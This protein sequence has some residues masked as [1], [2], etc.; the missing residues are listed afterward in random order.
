MYELPRRFLD[1]RNHAF[2]C[3]FA[4]T[5]AAEVKVAHVAT[6]SSALETAANNPR[7]EFRREC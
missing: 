5:N 6:L 4:E 7:L 3:K 2:V 1:A